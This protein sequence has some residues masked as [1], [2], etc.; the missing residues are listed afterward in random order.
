ML[1]Y[2][3][4]GIRW[5]ADGRALTY[6]DNLDGISNI[7]DQPLDGGP[8]VQLTKFDWSR[9]GKQLAF[10]RGARAYDVVLICDLR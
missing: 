5:T 6:V 4:A 7:C 10:S 1:V 2:Q 3:P 9:D 8:P